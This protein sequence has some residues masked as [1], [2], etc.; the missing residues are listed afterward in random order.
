M[1]SPA[2]TRIHMDA[3]S[4]A[5]ADLTSLDPLP[6]ALP[7]AGPALR[8]KQ[9]WRAASGP[10]PVRPAGAAAGVGPGPAQPSRPARRHAPVPPGALAHVPARRANGPC[11][12]PSCG[13]WGG[14]GGNAGR[15][16]GPA[17]RGRQHEAP[18]HGMGGVVHGVAGAGPT[19]LPAGKL[20]FAMLHVLRVVAQCTRTTFRRLPATSTIDLLH[21]FLPLVSLQGHTFCGPL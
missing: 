8:A 18:R 16:A 17:A 5:T 6:A 19:R 7:T 13:G 20:H 9:V 15:H 21:G 12:R 3:T 1:H 14:P 2:S 10:L 11:H 4:F